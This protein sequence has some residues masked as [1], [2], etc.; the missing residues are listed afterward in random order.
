MSYRLGSGIN[1]T[2]TDRTL[3]HRCPAVTV[4]VGGPGPEWGSVGRR[5]S[6]RRPLTRRVRYQRGRT[7]IT[8]TQLL[9]N[10]LGIKKKKK[11]A[12]TLEKDRYIFMWHHQLGLEFWTKDTHRHTEWS[13]KQ[14]TMLSQSPQ[15]VFFLFGPACFVWARYRGYWR[16]HVPAPKLSTWVHCHRGVC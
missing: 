13:R 10:D 3:P 11:F 15:C 8:D 16:P 5:G 12:F 2:N 14:T 6:D 9:S 1:V 4:A 7:L